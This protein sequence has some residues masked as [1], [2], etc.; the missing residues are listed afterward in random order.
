M[1]AC[2]VLL[3]KIKRIN[4]NLID[5]NKALAQFNDNARD[6]KRDN[7]NFTIY[8]S[9]E[10]PYVEYKI[11]G[12]S[13]YAKANN[14][15]INIV[16][17]YSLKKTKNLPCAFNNWANFY[18]GKFIYNIILKK[19]NF[20]EKLIKQKSNPAIKFARLLFS[21]LTCFKIV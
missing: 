14:I 9:N 8:Y 13:D 3:D 11:K 4:D 19:A 6:I 7:Q 2:E 18:K 15:N 16:K 5:D 17:I 1:L 12:L 21:Y 20:F 10:C